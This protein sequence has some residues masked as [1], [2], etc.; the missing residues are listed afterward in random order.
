MAIVKRSMH[1]SA[2]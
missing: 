1:K 2:F